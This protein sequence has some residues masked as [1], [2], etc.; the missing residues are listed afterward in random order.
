MGFWVGIVLV[1]F[2]VFRGTSTD[3]TSAERA[4]VLAKNEQCASSAGYTLPLALS[5]DSEGLTG[6]L[7]ISAGSSFM[8]E[9]P[10]SLG[11]C[12]PPDPAEWKRH[13]YPVDAPVG[14]PVGSPVEAS[15]AF[16]T[17]SVYV[18]ATHPPAQPLARLRMPSAR[19]SFKY[20]EARDLD[21]PKRA[22]M[23]SMVI[24]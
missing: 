11:K 9:A 2:V 8:L 16:A 5:A 10:P 23:A 20:L 4:R 7:R 1:P 3:P 21:A 6:R 12:L 19:I 13:N 22:A 18:A 15:G 17:L 14:S 24:P